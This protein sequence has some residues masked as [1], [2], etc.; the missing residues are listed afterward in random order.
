MDT[1]MVVLRLVHIFAGIA[2]VG[3][4]FFMMLVLVPL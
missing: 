1:L 4:G 2:W 3:A